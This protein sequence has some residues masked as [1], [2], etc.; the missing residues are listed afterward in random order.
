MIR[1]QASMTKV[2][3]KAYYI[4]FQMELNCANG[5]VKIASFHFV[6]YVL[7]EM[8]QTCAYD[9]VFDRSIEC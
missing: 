7:V 1:E 4:L 3:W 6:K 9:Y 5:G 8:T 2:A